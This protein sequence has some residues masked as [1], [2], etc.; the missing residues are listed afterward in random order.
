M[1]S[2]SEDKA[3]SPHARGLVSSG[4]KGPSYREA[5]TTSKR[6]MVGGKATEQV[7]QV[8]VDRRVLD[9]LQQSFVEVW[10]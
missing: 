5:L 4:G 9:E 2:S 3:S 8:E 6:I 1:A 7:I 10:R